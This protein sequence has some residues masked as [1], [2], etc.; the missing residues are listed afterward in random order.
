MDQFP[1]IDVSEW[2]D[3]VPEP[4]GK[5]RTKDW[6]L[7]PQKV[8]SLFKLPRQGEP[9]EVWAEKL[10]A[11]LA[12]LIGLPAA[13]IDLAID[14]DWRG[15]ISPTFLKTSLDT[16]D[17]GRVVK[18]RLV[19]EE[20]LIHGHQLLCG[21]FPDYPTELPGRKVT[22]YTVDRV[23]RVLAGATPP[24]RWNVSAETPTARTVFVGYLVFDAWIGNMDR[25]HHN[26]GCIT[27]LDGGP[28][29]LAPTF[30]HGSSLAF[31]VRDD[32]RRLARSDMGRFVR[33]DRSVFHHPT[34]G[35][36]I[37]TLD[38]VACALAAEPA[39]CAF[40]MDRVFAV[41]V[42]EVQDL[43]GAI[44]DEFIDND[45]RE[46]VAAFLDARASEL[47]RMRGQ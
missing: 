40:W 8:L 2:R 27:D 44:P 41:N 24:R 35:N 30:D 21:A 25:H 20:D 34:S 28:R 13:Q 26:W 12:T 1:I 19:R 10:A 4:I 3:R 42:D 38:A 43:I 45:Q 36:K 14:G 18:T 6:R 29:S 33:G 22:V 7:S 32:R 17:S 9:D 16:D 31:N 15:T 5:V 39:A 47:R 11:E 46:F 23:L 37:S